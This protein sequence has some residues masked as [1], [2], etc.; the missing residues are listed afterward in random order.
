MSS[1]LVPRNR[2]RSSADPD[3]SAREWHPLRV[4][5]LLQ[6]KSRFRAAA[7]TRRA[8]FRFGEL[9]LVSTDFRQQRPGPPLVGINLARL[10]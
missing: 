9:C 3:V 8:S 2:N 10:E 1:L 6:V 7:V 4:S 5:L